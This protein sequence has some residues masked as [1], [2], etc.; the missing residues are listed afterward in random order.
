MGE[1]PY[2]CRALLLEHI[3]FLLKISFFRIKIKDYGNRHGNSSADSGF[4]CHDCL[5]YLCTYRCEA[6]LSIVSHTRKISTTHC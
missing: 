6:L 1:S 3:V 4:G 2:L 5:V